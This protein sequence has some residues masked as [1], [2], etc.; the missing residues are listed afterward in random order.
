MLP[1]TTVPQQIRDEVFF[2]QIE[3]G[4][5]LF[6]N[7]NRKELNE[8]QLHQCNGYLEDMQ[9]LK[10]GRTIDEERISESAFHQY[11]TPY[12]VPNRPEFL[13]Y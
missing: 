8:K 5:C 1:V 6:D 4:E 11:C 10:K 9:T 2:R 12:G 3:I 13:H 7:P